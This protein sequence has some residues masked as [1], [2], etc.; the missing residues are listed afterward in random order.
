MQSFLKKNYFNLLVVIF[1]KVFHLVRPSP[2]CIINGNTEI[3]KSVSRRYPNDFLRFI[4]VPLF[5]YFRE[6]L[7]PKESGENS[8]RH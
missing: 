3:H 7:Y 2:I 5:A 1:R 8:P 4:V 6:S